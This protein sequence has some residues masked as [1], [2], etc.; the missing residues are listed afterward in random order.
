M[1][2]E[3]VIFHVHQPHWSFPLD[4]NLEPGV[5]IAYHNDVSLP[6]DHP[7]VLEHPVL[8]GRDRARTYL[9]PSIHYLWGIRLKQEY[10]NDW[11]T[12]DDAF[13]SG[14]MCQNTTW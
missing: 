6:L 13:L 12:D 10:P 7:H 9:C 4:W 8:R 5:Q 1:G 14:P 3:C 2:S 11:S